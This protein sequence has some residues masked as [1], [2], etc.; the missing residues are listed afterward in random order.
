[1]IQPWSANPPRDLACTNNYGLINALKMAESSVIKT[2]I[3]IMFTGLPN[4]PNLFPF[5]VTA[6][7]VRGPRGD[8]S[9]SSRV[10]LE[11]PFTFIGTEYTRIIVRMANITTAMLAYFA[12]PI[13]CGN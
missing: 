12:G 2:F 3:I 4:R 13:P 10:T 1:M 6:D 9:A 5:G 8:D 11:V 7:D